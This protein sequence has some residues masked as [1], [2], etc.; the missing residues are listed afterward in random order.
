MAI[1]EWPGKSPIE[2]GSPFHPAVYHMLDVAAVA[3]QLVEPFKFDRQLKEALILLIA[4][5]D[6]GKVSQ[7]FF[8]M[9][10][11]GQ[12]GGCFRHW[13]LT[14]ILLY[15]FDHILAAR[16][17]ADPV[18]RQYLYAAVAGHH[19]RP[20]NLDLGQL[21]DKGCRSRKYRRALAEIGDAHSDAGKTVEA[22][23]DLW[24]E[25]CLGNLDEQQAIQL[26]WWLPGL[27]TTADWVGSNQDWF[28]PQPAS[29]SPAAYLSNA[30]T[31]AQMAVREAGLASTKPIDTRLFDF[32]LRPMQDACANVE[33]THESMLVIIEDETGSG[34]TEAALLLAQ[35]MLLAGKGRGLFFALPTMATA[36]AMFTRATEVVGKLFDTGV[37]VTLAHGRAGL[38]VDFKEVCATNARGEDEPICTDWLA[39]SR[40]R[41]LLANVGIGTIDQALLSVLPARY[42]T[43]RHF[44]LSSKILIV[45]EVHELGDPYLGA[46]LEALLKMHRA[47]GG[48][49]ILMTATL[50]LIQRQRL[51]AVYGGATDHQAYPAL[52]VASGQAVTDLPQRPSARGPI[53]INRLTDQSQAIDL[54]ERSAA[55]GA[56]SVWIRNAVD[57]A[58]AAV[59]ALRARGVN[60][61]LLHARFTLFDRKRIEAEVLARVGNRGA[62]RA[63]FVL[64]GTQVLESSLDLDFDVMISDLAPV[65][66]LIQRAGRLWRHMDL[67]PARLRPVPHPVLHVL[68]PDPDHVTDNRW[69]HTVLNKGAYVYPVS[70]LWRTAKVLFAAGQISAPS[71]LRSLIEPVHGEARIPVPN[72]LAA[73]EESTVGQAAAHRAHAHQNIINLDQDYRMGGRADDDQ[74]YPTRLGELQLVL[75]LARIERGG[76]LPWAREID[77]AWALSEVSAPQRRLDAFK[78]DQ[79]GT[80]YQDVINGWPRW[81]RRQHRL[82]IVGET[83][84][85]CEGL[86]YDAALGLM[87]EK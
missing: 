22:F 69:L 12:T 44:G 45:D 84:E 15:E 81:K 43:L 5:H 28:K 30:R 80:A 42:Q 25:A 64:V 9:I 33:L 1:L 34:K 87:F 37:T 71:D 82:A 79:T 39:D 7:L 72:A 21:C 4:L 73:A 68:S 59:S 60:A 62:D 11:H 6:L 48:S 27:C 53:R 8:K 77:D 23:C 61:R 49:A 38:S 29:I 46:Q 56:A 63:G 55:S 18:V 32:D 13:E 40:R 66:A 3:E 24:P 74:T 85:I 35:R 78:F 31:I 67:R 2:D 10:K 65:A 75:V 20:P 54:L 86:R 58:I 14:E 26:S 52:T 36:D 47:A 70:D 19:G 41:A 51:L 83:G 57:D 17:G 76:L 16:L 50:P